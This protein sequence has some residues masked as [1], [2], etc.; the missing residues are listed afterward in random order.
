MQEDT[1]RGDGLNL[2]AYCA[3]N[4]VMYYDVSGHDKATQTNNVSSGT[5]AGEID[6]EG[7]SNSGKTNFIV[8]PNGIVVDANINVSSIPETQFTDKNLQHEFKHASDF[9]IT[10][11]WNKSNAVEYQ[12]AIESHISSSTDIF[13]STYRGED[14][15][16]YFN[17][18]TQIGAYV[19]YQGSYVGVGNFHRIK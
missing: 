16:V 6:F 18:S 8:S 15:Y 4:P 13:I 3:N 11:N 2:Y 10:G 12:Q 1:Y 14:V 19:D 7:G 9:G 17:S 5:P